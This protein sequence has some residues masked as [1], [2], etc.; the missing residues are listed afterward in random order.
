MG[1]EILDHTGETEPFDI[2]RAIEKDPVAKW[3]YEEKSILYS[4][5]EDQKFENMINFINWLKVNKPEVKDTLY[6]H[7][8][9][10]STPLTEP[11]ALDLDDEYSIE[12]FVRDGFPEKDLKHLE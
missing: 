6:F 9:I 4:D 11:K 5:P 2:L 12:K 8:L 10:G 3:I 7:V 1:H